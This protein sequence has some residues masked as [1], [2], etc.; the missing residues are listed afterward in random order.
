MQKWC[1]ALVLAAVTGFSAQQSQAQT[2]VDVS[3]FDI[4]GIRLRMTIAE[5]AAALKRRQE[6]D[7]GEILGEEDLEKAV[8]D[9]NAVTETK[10]FGYSTPIYKIGVT[11]SPAYRVESKSFPPSVIDVVFVINNYDK[12][13]D[14][15]QQVI[16]RYGEPSFHNKI[17]GQVKYC[18]RL[19]GEGNNKTCDEKHGETLFFV[20]GALYLSDKEFAELTHAKVSAPSAVQ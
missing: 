17:T 10:Y 8:K 3:R 19:I 2:A 16:E 6:K 12:H 5:V 9:Y 7:G 13:S 15:I 14:A 11:L 1:C 18:Q 20:N 4:A